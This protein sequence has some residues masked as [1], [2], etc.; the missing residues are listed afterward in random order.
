LMDQY[1]P[2][3]PG[4]RLLDVG[5]GAGNMIHHLSHYGRSRAWRSIP[6]RSRWLAAR[7]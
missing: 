7:L 3:T 2:K 6:A 5:C 4:F 1:L